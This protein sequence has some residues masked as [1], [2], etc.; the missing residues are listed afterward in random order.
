MT[1]ALNPMEDTT[2]LS[3][4]VTEA[5]ITAFDALTRSKVDFSVEKRSVFLATG[6]VVPGHFATVRTDNDH[7]LGMVG[8]RYH[9]IQ[10]QAGLDLF[11]T[12]AAAGAI[13]YGRAGTFKAGAITW[14]QAKLPN[15]I[16]VGPDEVDRFLLLANTHDGSGNLRILL[17]PIRVV[18]RNTLA[19]ALDSDAGMSI[20]HTA[21]ASAK[22]RAATAAIQVAGRYYAQF[23]DVANVMFS[24]R[25]GLS[26]TRSAIESIFPAKDDAETSTR[27]DNVRAKVLD[28]I[29]T[30][31]GQYA[32]RGTAWGVYNAVAEYTDHHRSTRGDDSNRLESSWFGSGAGIKK[33]AF[34]VL[35]AA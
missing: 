29:E 15:S 20:R 33:R 14:L 30:G 23:Q 13:E 17:T 32:I 2:E 26:E 7:V 12:A 4:L 18:C 27:L 1:L 19:A 10:N 16:K 25:L 21:S 11:D 24:K 35:M 8:P 28:L 5:R 31:K 9:V 34:D 22:V 3:T 6:S